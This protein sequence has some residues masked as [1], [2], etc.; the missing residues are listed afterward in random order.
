MNGVDNIDF[1]VYLYLKKMFT[2]EENICKA[3]IKSI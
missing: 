1:L 3:L 2:I